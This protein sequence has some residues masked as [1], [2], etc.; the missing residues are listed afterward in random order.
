MLSHR[1]K[2]NGELYGGRYSAASVGR[3]LAGPVS[4]LAVRVKLRELEEYAGL[5]LRLELDESEYRV[6]DGDA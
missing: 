4:E 6:Y 2:V 5:R 1:V 3:W